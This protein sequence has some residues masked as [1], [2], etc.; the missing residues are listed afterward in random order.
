MVRGVQFWNWWKKI[1]LDLD[2]VKQ[3]GFKLHASFC[4][5]E[6]GDGKGCDVD[7]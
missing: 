5:I 3:E 1:D 4:I 7:R 2:R 6:K